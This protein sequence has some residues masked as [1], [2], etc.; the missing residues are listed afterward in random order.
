MIEIDFILEHFRYK[1]VSLER[2]KKGLEIHM[3]VPKTRRCGLRQDEC[4]KCGMMN[5]GETLKLQI[6]S[7]LLGG[8]LKFSH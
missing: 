3:P 6:E 8:R 7:E 1:L 5:L 4:N 2:M